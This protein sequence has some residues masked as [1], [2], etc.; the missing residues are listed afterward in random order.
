MKKVLDYLYSNDNSFVD[1]MM[2]QIAEM[3]DSYIL[4]E[5]NKACINIGVY[6]DEKRLKKWLE[7]CASLENIDTEVA[8]DLALRSKLQRLEAENLKLNHKTS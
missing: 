8:V 1:K 4:G 2:I 3:R 5:I 7:M 6:V